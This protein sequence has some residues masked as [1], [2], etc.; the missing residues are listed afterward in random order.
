[1]F[2]IVKYIYSLLCY[3]LA[4]STQKNAEETNSNCSIKLITQTVFAIA[5]LESLYSETLVSVLPRKLQLHGI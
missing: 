5:E 1:M 2:L 4:N 3:L